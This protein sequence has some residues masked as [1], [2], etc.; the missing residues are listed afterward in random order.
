MNKNVVAALC[1]GLLLFQSMV[2]GQTNGFLSN[3]I[4]VL[5]GLNDTLSI[6]TAKNDQISNTINYSLSHIT[7]ID[8]TFIS[9]DLN[10]K[11][12]NFEKNTYPLDLAFGDGITVVTFDTLDG[13]GD[14][15]ILLVNHKNNTTSKLVFPWDSLKTDNN[16]S[17]YTV[18]V[19]F[20]NGAF[21]FACN[22][23]GLV[24]YNL[25]DSSKTVLTPG[26]VGTVSTDQFTGITDTLKRVTS[27]DAVNDF[28]IITTPSITYIYSLSDSSWTEFNNKCLDPGVTIKEF[29]YST[30][31]G[32]SPV[33]PLY[34]IAKISKT[35]IES[36][37]TVLCKFSKKENGWRVML[38]YEING[39]SFGPK[40]YLYTFSYK[41]STNIKVYHDTL[42]DSGVTFSP[43]AIDLYDIPGRI[44]RGSDVPYI[45]DIQFIP[46]TDSSG[47]LWVATSSG[48]FLS[49]NEIPGK[50]T[51]PLICIKRV[52][53]VKSGL[54]QAFASPGILKYEGQI[55]FVYN[56]SKSGKVT[57]R[58]YDFNM[59]LV[60]TIID[61][62]PR[63]AGDQSTESGRSNDKLKDTWDGTNTNGKNCAPGVYYFKITTDIGEH[64][65]GKIVVA[66]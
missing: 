19:A 2:C 45:N 23:G 34:S 41:D 3:N 43:T 14:N 42:G 21:Y 36:D 5:S 37:T 20:A 50:S 6:L 31:D 55:R 65:F 49:P 40:G 7:S 29:E 27:V 35:G 17:T 59:D 12:N 46:K 56:L 18:S 39:L 62:Q 58:V 66:K 4:Q 54:K 16:K 25:K 10:W 57:I 11:T 26:A 47:V 24:R 63:P 1:T 22:D 8:S 64:A 28:L 38:D 48:L 13:G 32:I 53:S 30:V 60:K 15:Q 52:A 33:N 44:T 9:N 61:N 51:D